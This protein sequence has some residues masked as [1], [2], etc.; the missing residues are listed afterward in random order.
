MKDLVVSLWLK[1][2]PFTMTKPA[3][4]S[5]GNM[6]GKGKDFLIFYVIFGGKGNEGEKA[7]NGTVLRGAGKA[8]PLTMM[9]RPLMSGIYE[10]RCDH[11]Q[12]VSSGLSGERGAHIG[13]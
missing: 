8:F 6:V 1:L 11:P 10:K 9:A 4:P 7:E 13:R 5:K 2:S 12:Q 3:H